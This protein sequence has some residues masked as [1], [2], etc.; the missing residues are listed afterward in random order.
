MVS[1]VKGRG[2]EVMVRYGFD[3][4]GVIADIDIFKLRVIDSM[5]GKWQ[6][7]LN[8]WYYGTRE[9]QLNPNMF[10]YEGDEIYIITSRGEHLE[11][12]TKQWLKKN[13][14][15]YD[16]LI[17]VHHNP[18]KYIG[19]ELEEWFKRQAQKKA[20]VLKEN[21]I[22]VYF[23]DTPSTVKYLREM[24]DNIII[25]QYGNRIN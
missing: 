2:Y 12:I 15:P 23:E 17:F 13:S 1:R 24:C 19:N 6:G 20:K 7:E 10:V 8:N 5:S 16:K 4:D 11:E 25:I 18:G 21:K 22:E 3:L 9:Y 14:V